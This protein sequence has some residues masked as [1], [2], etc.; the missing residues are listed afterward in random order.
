[1]TKVVDAPSFFS[2]FKTRSIDD[3]P[4]DNEEDEEEEDFMGSPI[5]EDFELGNEIR[6]EIV[7]NAAL[8]Y[9]GARTEEEED[10]DAE[11][12]SKGIKVDGSGAQ[13]GDCKQQ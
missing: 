9:L 2:F 6:D 12:E 3:E 1:M 8:Y 10:S 13:K 7:P 11:K 5:D 4:E